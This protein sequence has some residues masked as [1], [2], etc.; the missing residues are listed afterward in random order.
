MTA[1]LILVAIVILAVSICRMRT[2]TNDL[3]ALSER[4]AADR[5]RPRSGA[6][7]AAPCNPPIEGGRIG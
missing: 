4:E 6:V 5:L 1:A 7:E 3:A 2:A